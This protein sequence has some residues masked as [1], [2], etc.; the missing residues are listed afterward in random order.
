MAR[1]RETSAL[2]SKIWSENFCQRRKKSKKNKF[3]CVLRSRE[4]P[5][6]LPPGALIRR[7]KSGARIREQSEA[8]LGSLRRAW[9]GGI[10]P[11]SGTGTG[12]RPR[13]ASCLRLAELIP[14]ATRFQPSDICRCGATILFRVSESKFWSASKPRYPPLIPAKLPPRKPN[15]PHLV[16][17]PQRTP[18]TIADSG[19]GSV[20]RG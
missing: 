10:W 12:R 14:A 6:P 11:V 18:G 19:G 5:A 4:R 17:P 1:Q 15:S 20:R 9:C 7:G 3:A 2:Q 8:V 16:V 13:K